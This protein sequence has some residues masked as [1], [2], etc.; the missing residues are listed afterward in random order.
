MMQGIQGIFELGFMPGVR[1][2]KIV[3]LNQP[4]VAAIDVVLL[5]D[6]AKFKCSS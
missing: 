5:K 3:F 4:T 2:K 1:K 6:A